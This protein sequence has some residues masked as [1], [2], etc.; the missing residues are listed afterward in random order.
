MGKIS[1]SLTESTFRKTRGRCWYC[2]AKKWPGTADDPLGID[3]LTPRSRGGTDDAENLVPC[4]KGC[5]S[6][7][8]NRTIDE[9][10]HNFALRQ[11]G[12]PPFTREMIDW[13]TQRGS[14]LRPYFE[15]RLWFERRTKAGT[16]GSGHQE[17]IEAAE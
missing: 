17:I 6:I 7:K 8:G 10:R 14:D 1:A 15:H 2:G 4:C 11:L 13:M 3:H 5:N 12:W 16:S 9:A